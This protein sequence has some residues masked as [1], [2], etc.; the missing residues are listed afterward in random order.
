MLVGNLQ[1]KLAG[2]KLMNDHVTCKCG[3]KSSIA[4]LRYCLKK[5]PH[6]SVKTFCDLCKI[7]MFPLGAR[8]RGLR[9]VHHVKTKFLEKKIANKKNQNKHTC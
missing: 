7:D 9:F 4:V 6:P 5:P 2:N 1:N 8:L 3:K